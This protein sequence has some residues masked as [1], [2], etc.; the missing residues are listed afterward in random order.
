MQTGDLAGIR[1]AEKGSQ[2]SRRLATLNAGWLPR[3]LTKH[4]RRRRAGANSPTPAHAP[5]LSDAN[6]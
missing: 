2:T 5:A 6:Q 1:A 3:C 4:C